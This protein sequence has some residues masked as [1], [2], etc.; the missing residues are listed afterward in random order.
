MDPNVALRELLQAVLAGD[1]EQAHELAEGLD[2][3]LRRGGFSPLPVADSSYQGWK[4]HETWAVHLSLTGDEKT[5]ALCCALARESVARAATCVPVRDGHWTVDQA[6]RSVLAD[7]LKDLVD[8][9]SP[10]VDVAS[11]Y[12]DLL[13]SA[14]YKVDWL[15]I[16]DAFLE[17]GR[18]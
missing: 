3:W 1:M 17:R 15:A 5:D 18:R 6:G 12:S 14:L 11:V 2:Q 13:G 7:R 8:S 4:N 10:L 9:R 16:A